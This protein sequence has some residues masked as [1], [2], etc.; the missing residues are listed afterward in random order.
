ME[1]GGN[2]RCRLG[3]GGDGV[4]RRSVR[5]DR[6]AEV[7]LALDAGPRRTDRSLGVWSTE[8]QPERPGLNR[9]DRQQPSVDPRIFREAAPDFVFVGR[10]NEV[11]CLAMVTDRPAKQD[12]PVLDETVHE[13]R[14]RFPAL[15]LADLA[16]LVPGRPADEGHCEARRAR[17]HAPALSAR[18]RSNSMTGPTLPSSGSPRA[19]TRSTVPA[20]K[21][22][23]RPVTN[24]NVTAARSFAYGRVMRTLRA[25]PPSRL[26]A[27]EQVLLRELADS[28]LFAPRFDTDVSQT[29]ADVRALLLSLRSG[30]FDR[31]VDGLAED[32]EACAP[33]PRAVALAGRRA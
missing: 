15:L 33:E 18:V 20:R 2:C 27:G 32:L 1:S 28:L 31:W 24:L 12:E 10:F 30:P 13:H 8:V 25:S 16:G 6:M 5:L 9:P 21:K 14:M 4:F 23:G 17:T 3:P 19:L 22:R 7:L 26:T 29:L 11:E